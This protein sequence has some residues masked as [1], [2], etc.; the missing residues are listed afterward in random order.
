MLF[1]IEDKEHAN[2]SQVH[3]PFLTDIDCIGV[4]KFDKWF[5]LT[6]VFFQIYK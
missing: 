2:T 1:F 3:L 6:I 5:L 4:F